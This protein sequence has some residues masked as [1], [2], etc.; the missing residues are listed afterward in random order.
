M[1]YMTDVELK[2]GNCHRVINRIEKRFRRPDNVLI[3]QGCR[4]RRTRKPTGISWG[5]SLILI[6]LALLLGAG[7]LFM[8]KDMSRPADFLDFLLV[9][10]GG[11]IL[12]TSGLLIK[13]ISVGIREGS[14]R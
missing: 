1:W 9:G 13:I 8:A 2:C 14:R 3:C 6:G 5:A 10:V 12:F 7:V 4:D 11:V